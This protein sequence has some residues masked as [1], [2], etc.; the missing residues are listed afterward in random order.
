MLSMNDFAV[1]KVTHPYD[2]YMCL[3]LWRGTLGISREF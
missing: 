2:M 3:C 1:A